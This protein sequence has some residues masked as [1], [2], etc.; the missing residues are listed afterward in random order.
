LRLEARAGVTALAEWDLV[1]KEIGVQ[2]RGVAGGAMGS[3]AV[4]KKG[5]SI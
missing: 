3:T 5:E 2:I 4:A 1:H